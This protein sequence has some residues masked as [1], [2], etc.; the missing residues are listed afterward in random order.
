MSFAEH[1]HKKFEFDRA[2]FEQQKKQTKMAKW[3]KEIL[4]KH[5]ADRTKNDV[6]QLHDMFRGLSHFEK[7]TQKVQV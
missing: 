4:S 7:F 6:K 5:P 1:R 2:A 3:M